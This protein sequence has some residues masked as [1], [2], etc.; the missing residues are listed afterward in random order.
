MFKYT[1]TVILSKIVLI[2]G[3]RKKNI[4]AKLHSRGNYEQFI[5]IKDKYHQ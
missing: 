3:P 1:P 5:F 4:V 2:D